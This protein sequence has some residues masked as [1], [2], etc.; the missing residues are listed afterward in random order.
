MNVG[1]DIVKNSRLKNIKHFATRILS[2]DELRKFNKIN[3]E[4]RM[5][6]FVSGRWAAKEAIFKCLDKE[7]YA[8][9]EINI[10]K[11]K[12]KLIAKVVNQ[13][14][15][16]SISHEREYSVAVAICCS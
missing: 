14:I 11:F 6:E 9:S 12:N 7:S 15:I 8:Y 4:R 1:I 3:T 5:R 16:I 10:F 2:V 13:K